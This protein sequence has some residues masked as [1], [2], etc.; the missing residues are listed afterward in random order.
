M[1]TSLS[2][3]ATQ[4]ARVYLELLKFDGEPPMVG[5]LDTLFDVIAELDSLVGGH[6][7]EEI[8]AVLGVADDFAQE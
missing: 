6:A 7:R 8:R 5:L 1:P 2:E 4:L 3:L